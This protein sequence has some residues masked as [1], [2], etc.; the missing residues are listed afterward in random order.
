M[1]RFVQRGVPF[2]DMVHDREDTNVSRDSHQATS[3]PPSL[4]KKENKEVRE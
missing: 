4:I 3:G 1:L 2:V